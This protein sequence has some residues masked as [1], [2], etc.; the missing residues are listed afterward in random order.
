MNPVE[1]IKTVRP[2]QSSLDNRTLEERRAIYANWG[3]H[4]E[5][6]LAERQT[7]L[8]LLNAAYRGLTLDQA[9][10]L[11]QLGIERYDAALAKDRSESEHFLARLASFVLGAPV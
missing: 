6:I 5:H 9:H 7:N 2:G 11:A 3:A 8:E 1:V 4:R 10:E